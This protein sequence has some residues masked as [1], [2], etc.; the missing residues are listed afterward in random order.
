MVKAVVNAIFLIILMI[1][2]M[3]LISWCINQLELDKAPL[4]K[5]LI[6]NVQAKV[7]P[8]P[9][10]LS[11]LTIPVPQKPTVRHYITPT[12]SLKEPT[13]NTVKETLHFKETNFYLDKQER[14]RF[15]SL[16]QN[17]HLNSAS[18][19]QVLTGPSPGG[20]NVLT[21]QTAKL[22]AQTVARLIYPY[23]QAIKMH[24]VSSLESGVV[25]VEFS[26]A[27]NERA[28]KP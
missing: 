8:L 15:E 22:R 27:L 23:T 4:E 24:Y 17:L 18:A 7:G 6:S 21:L 20:E 10:N 11:S 25:V 28:K 5:T 19:V 13:A 12:E 1:G 3:A 9:K 2:N 26:Q 14:K 16:L